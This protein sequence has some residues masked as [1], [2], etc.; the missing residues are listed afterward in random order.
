[1]ENKRSLLA[2]ILGSMAKKKEEEVVEVAMDDPNERPDERDR[3][4]LRE[5]MARKAQSE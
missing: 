5:E 4:L 3:R 2:I 1:M